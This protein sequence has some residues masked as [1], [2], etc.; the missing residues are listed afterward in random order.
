M[1]GREVCAVDVWNTG[2][3]LTGFGPAAD[4]SDSLQF[5]N[6]HRVDT[7][8]RDGW[9]W[10]VLWTRVSWEAAIGPLSVLSAVCVPAAPTS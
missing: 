5:R 9:P 7:T 4:R 1:N 3:V 8:D 6:A 2:Q 10:T